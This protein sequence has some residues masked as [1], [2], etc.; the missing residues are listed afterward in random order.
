[1]I[2]KLN[3][4]VGSD[5]INQKS[6]VKRGSKAKWSEGITEYNFSKLSW[7]FFCIHL[8]IFT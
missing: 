2:T 4:R 3:N 6:E 8:P 7:I 1:M 5:I